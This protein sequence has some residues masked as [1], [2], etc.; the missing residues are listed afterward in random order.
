MGPIICLYLS[1]KS[2]KGGC[3]QFFI[4]HCAIV[5]AFIK[6]KLCIYSK[7]VDPHRAPEKREYLMTME[8]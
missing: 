5:A 7:S 2:I 4:I 1:N 8:G 6:K 3:V